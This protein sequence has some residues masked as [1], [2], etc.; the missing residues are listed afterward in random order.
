MAKTRTVAKKLREPKAQVNG[1]S[2]AADANL[3]QIYRVTDK[4]GQ[5]DILRYAEMPGMELAF[6]VAHFL[7]LDD[8]FVGMLPPGAQRNYWLAFADYDSRRKLA[9][10]ALYE[11]PGSSDPRSK[12]LDGPHGKANPLVRD[13]EFVQGKVGRDWYITWRV[14]GGQGDFTEALESGFRVICRPKDARE[15]EEKTPF[16]WSGEQWKV[17]DGTVDPTSGDEIF[18]VM[19]Y[20]RQKAFD[21]HKLAM[22]MVSHNAYSTVKRE[23]VDGVDN[24]SR[25]MSSSKERIQVSDLDELHVEEHTLVKDGKRVVIDS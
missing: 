5:E 25:D 18:N 9:D 11:T 21:D 3:A 1:P 10:R 4:T 13:A 8:S 17:R 23:F 2:V 6:D 15:R 19:V 22:S 12:L 14:Q 16:E 7:K 24:I 20:I